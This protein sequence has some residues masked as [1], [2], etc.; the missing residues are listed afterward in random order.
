MSLPRCVC[1]IMTTCPQM[2]MSDTECSAQAE[3]GLYRRIQ[4]SQ[5]ARER[6]TK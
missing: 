5:T 6:W 3:L 1:Q 2:F 4:I